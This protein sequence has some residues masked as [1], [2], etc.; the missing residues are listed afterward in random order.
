MG[1][2]SAEPQRFFAVKRLI[3]PRRLQNAN[4]EE[5]KKN[6]FNN[7]V[8][9]LKKFTNDAN[10]KH[11][12]KLL[13]T[14]Y[15]QGHYHL[16]FPWA[17]GSN[18][19]EYWEAT[20]I[21][22]HKYEKLLWIAQQVA[23]LTEALKKLHN[24]EF[25]VNLEPGVI[26]VPTSDMITGRHGDIKPANILVFY[27]KDGIVLKLSDFGLTRFHRMVTEHQL[28]LKVDGSKTYRG[29]EV[30]LRKG[31]DRLYDMWA[32]GCVFLEFISWYMLGF[33][34]G[35][36]DFSQLR[37]KNHD[38][39]SKIPEDS[40]FNVATDDNGSEFGACLKRCVVTVS[41]PPQE[42]F[43][44]QSRLFGQQHAN[45]FGSSESKTYTPRIEPANLSGNS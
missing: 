11:L 36:E 29:P 18:L 2:S 3:C 42:E 12:I 41:S 28:Y 43:V 34:A 14:Y 39:P 8:H 7:E 33:K 26:N 45:E 6:M 16:I 40:F 37:V 31:V 22:E 9:A 15:H 13:A 44:E 4:F 30:D 32:L 21:P 38:G 19:R 25:G 1:E 10:N 24:N 27:T 5:E 20:D 23:G 17:D 35:V